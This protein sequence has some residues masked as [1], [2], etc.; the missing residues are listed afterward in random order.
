MLSRWILGGV[1]GVLTVC[2]KHW[3]VKLVRRGACWAGHR[4][5]GWAKGIHSSRGPQGA[6]EGVRWA[7]GQIGG[8]EGDC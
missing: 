5:G 7:A 8:Q 6:S 3:E 4:P 2:Q 1:A